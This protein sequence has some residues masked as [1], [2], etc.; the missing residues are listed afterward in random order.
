MNKNLIVHHINLS[1]TSLN[2]SGGEKAEI[3]IIDYL[4]SKK[5][6]N[7]IY[8][9]ESAKILYQK[10]KNFP[11][12]YFVSI[13]SY[14]QEK[15]NI[16]LAYYLRFFQS[17]RYLSK[18]DSTYKHVIFTHDIFLQSILFSLCLKILNPKAKWVLLF[19]MKSPSLN[20]GFLGEFNN[21]YQIPDFKL[22]RFWANEKIALFLTKKVDKIIS[23]NIYN[24]NY[25][26][27]FNI[28]NKIYTLKCFGGV[29]YLKNKS[30]IIKKKYNFIFIGRFHKQKGFMDLLE[31]MLECK[32]SYPGIKLLVIG[33]GD[34]HNE[35]L[36]RNEISK[37][38]LENNIE[39]IGFIS[40]NRKYIYLNESELFLMPSYYEGSPLVILEAFSNGI[41]VVAYDLPIYK[42]FTN[43]VIKARI[44]D[45]KDFAY[46]ALEYIS[47]KRKY[48]KLSNKVKILSTE[49]SWKITCQ[50]IYKV[51]NKLI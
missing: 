29:D 15:I 4:C 20:K 41:P 51:I 42:Q 7:L 5:I 50:E 22:I 2:L 18:F 25:L 33:G 19:H 36:F 11:D 24:Y 40:D 23:V 35:K 8:S 28:N 9:S 48:S 43:Y 31:I 46:K 1:K 49:F 44:G 6:K 14:A 10:L 16:Y 30:T 37:N 47:D 3:E 26:A 32:K 21:T 39:F 13:G 12:N 27:K 38:R 34:V 45:R 17:I